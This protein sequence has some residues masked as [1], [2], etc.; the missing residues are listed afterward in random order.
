MK[1]VVA[2]V[3]L[4]FLTACEPSAE[5]QRRVTQQLP[6]GCTV[7]DVGSY[8]DVSHLIIVDCAGRQT[9]TMNYQQQSGKYIRPIA[10]VQWEPRTH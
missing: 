3:A 4:L 6:P 5:E 9:R 10:V 1:P 8:G 7:Q 2:I